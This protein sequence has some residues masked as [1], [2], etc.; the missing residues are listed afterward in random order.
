MYTPLHFKNGHHTTASTG[1]H[2]ARTGH[3][4]SLISV[5]WAL[6]S[7]WSATCARSFHVSSPRSVGFRSTPVVPSATPLA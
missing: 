6:K 4:G 2:T 1:H 7:R 3:H 5:H